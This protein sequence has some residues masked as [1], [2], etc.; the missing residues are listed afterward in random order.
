MNLHTT[1]PEFLRHIYAP[2]TTP[3]ALT[4]DGL[5]LCSVSNISFSCCL[6]LQKSRVRRLTLQLGSCK[7]LDLNMTTEDRQYAYIM[8]EALSNIN[9][10]YHVAQEVIQDEESYFHGIARRLAQQFSFELFYVHEKKKKELST[11][12]TMAIITA[13]LLLGNSLLSL[14][15]GGSP[16]AQAFKEMH[17]AAVEAAK[18]A[19]KAGTT[20]H[21]LKGALGIVQAAWIG[22]T[23]ILNAGHRDK[24][25]I[26]KYGSW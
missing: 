19:Q 12:I 15:P 23:G 26:C 18:A 7:A 22:G 11:A 17:P 6:H 25:V 13:S 8:F 21:R 9:H 10:A 16:A 1:F 4:C 3:S 14:I 2:E 20:L 5:G 24:F